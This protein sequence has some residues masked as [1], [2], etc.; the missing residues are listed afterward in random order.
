MREQNKV[1]LLPVLWTIPL[2]ILPKLPHWHTQHLPGLFLSNIL[3]F[4]FL[5]C[6]CTLRSIMMSEALSRAEG[7]HELPPF[8]Q[9]VL[10][11]QMS[12]HS[13]GDFVLSEGCLNR[14]RAYR[15]GKFE[16]TW[17]RRPARLH[18]SR[19][20]ANPRPISCEQPSK[21]KLSCFNLWCHGRV[22]LQVYRGRPLGCRQPKLSIPTAK[23]F[24]NE[25]SDWF[26]YGCIVSK[27]C[28]G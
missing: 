2:Q 20:L 17:Q 6:S 3:S 4:L 13:R 25:V 26:Y 18:T 10:V 12:D 16:T 23:E 24:R 11:L 7:W 19:R 14:T 28:C 5:L 8:C 15:T 1:I 9:S 27:R 22:G 21:N